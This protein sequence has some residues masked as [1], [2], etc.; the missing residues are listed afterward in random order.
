MADGQGQAE[1]LSEDALMAQL[2]ARHLERMKAFLDE[3]QVAVRPIEEKHRMRLR[4]AASV[5]LI[6]VPFQ[7]EPEKKVEEPDGG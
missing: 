3:V 1:E 6:G 7:P 2:R 4:P 5:A